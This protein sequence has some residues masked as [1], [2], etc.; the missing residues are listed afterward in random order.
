MAEQDC[1]YTLVLRHGDGTWE[2]TGHRLDGRV[3]VRPGRRRRGHR[4]DGRRRRSG[5]SRSPS[6]RA[7]TTWI[8]S[9]VRF[10]RTNA[11]VLDDLR[12]PARPRIRCSASSWR[13]W[14]AD[15][16]EGSRRSPWLSCDNI[17][18]NG[19]VSR[20]RCSRPTRG[21]AIRTSATGWTPPCGSPAR[22]STGSPRRRRTTTAWTWRGGSASRTGGRWLCE[23]FT[24]WVLEDEL[25]RRPPATGGCRRADR[26]SDVEPY[27]L[28]K[29]PAAQRE[30]PG[31]RGTRAISPATGSCTRSPPTRSSPGFLLDYMIDE[32]IPTLRPV[33][34]M[35]LD[36]Y[37]HEL[38]GR[39]SNPEVGRHRGPAL[40]QHLGPASP[41]SC[42]P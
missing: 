8:R 14:P 7:V 41:S 33:P 30:P 34:G 40:R 21:C 38:V 20:G 23:P 37:A 2:P 17:Q 27:E 13:R 18:G 1:L 39:F 15:G 16:P 6:P 22:W 5:S 19:H 25:Q 9:R 26:N 36:G 24:Q 29:T 12:T 4:E 32:A 28:A 10:D 31:P 11:A 35:D 3:S 42:C